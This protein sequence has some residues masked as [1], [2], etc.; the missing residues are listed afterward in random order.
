M[1]R[2]RQLGRIFFL[3]KKKKNNYNNKIIKREMRYGIGCRCC[4]TS[5]T[6]IIAPC[7]NGRIIMCNARLSSKDAIKH[8][9]KKFK[10]QLSSPGRRE[11]HLF[12]MVHGQRTNHKA[13]RWRKQCN[14]WDHKKL[15]QQTYHDR[16]TLSGRANCVHLQR[17]RR[18]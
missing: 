13:K 6:R 18:S 8:N 15:R 7:K 16:D 10:K 5:F 9:K 12:I 14:F 2:I 4:S 3:K 1:G 11:A 17:Y